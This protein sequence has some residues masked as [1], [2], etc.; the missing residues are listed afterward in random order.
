MEHGLLNIQGLAEAHLLLG[1]L[2][3]EARID[4]YWV[5]IFNCFCKFIFLPSNYM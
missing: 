5:T 3:L 4:I 1:I 2:S